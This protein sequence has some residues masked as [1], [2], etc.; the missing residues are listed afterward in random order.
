MSL[1]FVSCCVMGGLSGFQQGLELA[2]CHSVSD[3]VILCT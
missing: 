3:R 1:R 2:K